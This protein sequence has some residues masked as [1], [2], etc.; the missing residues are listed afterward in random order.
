VTTATNRGVRTVRSNRPF[1]PEP[2]APKHWVAKSAHRVAMSISYRTSLA[3]SREF[4]SSA[5]RDFFFS[6]RNVLLLNRPLRIPVGG[7]HYLLSPKGAVAL[8]VWAGRYPE[9]HDLQFFLGTLNPGMTLVDAGANV[10]LFSIPAAMIVD[11]GRVFAFEPSLLTYKRLVKNARLNH[12]SNLNAV[13]S[14]LGDYAGEAHLSVNVA[15]KDGLNTIGKPTHPQCEVARKESVPITTLDMF[16]AQ[17]GVTNVDA[18]KID[19]EGAEPLVLRGATKL[20]AR[21]DA[22]LILFECSMLTAGFGHHPVESVWLLEGLGYSLFAID[23][24][25]GTISSPFRNQS[26]DW[27]FTMAIAVKP[28]HPSY[29]VIKGRVR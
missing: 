21:P 14:A 15:G 28:G 9:R 13:R 24:N 27:N 18:M 16:L 26:F 25:D 3:F 10:G 5:K 22:P 19:V 23:P 7:Q 8:E 20:L 2:A 17:N 12:L 11:G 29:S 4:W 1:S 6:A